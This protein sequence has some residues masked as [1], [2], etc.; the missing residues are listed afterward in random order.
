MDDLPDNV[1]RTTYGPD[2]EHEPCPVCPSCGTPWIWIILFIAALLAIIG[3]VVWLIYIYHRNS[4]CKGQQITLTNPNIQVDSPTQITGTWTPTT[5]NDTV[6]LYA[7]LHPPVFG[8]T[9]G[10]DNT[11]AATNSKSAKATDGSVSLPGLTKGL[12]YYAT[13]IASN[14]K[15]NNYKSYTQIVYMLDSTIPT[16]IAGASGTSVHNTF[17]IQDILQ[18]G[19]IQIGTET[20]SDNNIFNVQFNQRPT[21]ARSLFYF[22]DKSQLQS[23]NASLENICLFNSSGNVIAAPCG[24]T[25][26]NDSK[27]TYNPGKLANRICLTSTLSSA[28]PTCIELSGLS[29]GTGTVITSTSSTAGDAFVLAFEN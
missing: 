16:N 13:L 11:S 20:T 23:S 3:L 22:N 18:V 17:E 6:T 14:S 19:A 4:T 15:T 9:G 7:T 1:Y 28:T 21:E 27:W 26:L 25:G 24:S 5:N 2:T 10:L 8:A 29:N 12:K